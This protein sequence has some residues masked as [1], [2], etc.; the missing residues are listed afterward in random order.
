MNPV[1]QKFGAP[2][3]PQVNLVPKEFHEKRTMRVVQT[4]AGLAVAGVIAL[5]AVV[6][7]GTWIAHSV[8]QD[9][10][11]D[12][13]ADEDVAVLDRDSRKTVYDAYVAQERSELTLAQIG[14]AEVDYANLLTATIAQDNPEIS[15]KR[16]EFV[17]PNAAGGASTQPVD[18]WDG[19][20]GTVHFEMYARTYE[21]GLK[22]IATLEAV[23]GIANA[24][25][26]VQKYD[27]QGAVVLW[28]VS[29]SAEITELFLTNRLTPVDGLLV[30][31]VLDQI[32]LSSQAGPP[33]APPVE[34]TAAPTA[35][36][37]P[38]P[39]SEG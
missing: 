14:W 18:L 16:L 23:P 37:S 15:F 17:L 26:M 5:I 30:Q 11:N 31:D 36:P 38:S 32:V 22:G 19:G 1:A 20:V 10:L 34:P 9:N 8:A 39:S 12:A 3:L 6:Y 24:Y 25:G 7:V 33:T 28:K 27:E 4:F 35:S 2:A 29:G 13:L 21:E